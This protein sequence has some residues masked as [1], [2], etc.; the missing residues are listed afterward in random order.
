[1]SDKDDKTIDKQD[2]ESVTGIVGTETSDTNYDDVNVDVTDN[3]TNANDKQDDSSANEDNAVTID[4]NANH[5]DVQSDRCAVDKPSNDE[6]T[7]EVNENNSYDGAHDGINSDASVAHDADII[8]ENDDNKQHAE[9]D[10]N[11]P[12]SA[13]DDKEFDNEKAADIQSTSDG[14]EK[15]DMK[16]PKHKID[17]AKK[18]ATI[19]CVSG[20]VLGGSCGY[21]LIPRIQTGELAGK[22]ELTTSEFDK[23]IATYN[24]KGHSYTIT[25]AEVAD[26]EGIDYG[27]DSD[28]NSNSNE[29]NSSSDENENDNEN[30]SGKDKTYDIPSTEDTIAAIRDKIL[31]KEM[32]DKKIEASDKQIKEYAKDNYGSDDFDSLASQYNVDKNVVE[33]SIKRSVR[34]RELYKQITGDYAPDRPNAPTSPSDTSDSSAYTNKTEDYGSYLMSI[35]KNDYDADKNEWKNK[36]GD[37]YEALKDEDFDGKTASYSTCVKAYK[38][39]YAQYSEQYDKQSK[40]WQ[41]YTTDL[42]ANTDVH[43]TNIMPSRSSN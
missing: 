20:L 17:K 25:A 15:V 26:Y 35:I 29:S 1:M 10:S 6:H 41:D 43:F 5:A 22:S 12:A 21:W 31:T 4:D 19:A 3:M 38:I 2:N 7:D 24:F 27:K 13:S 23:V 42:Y 36:S 39:A 37:Y 11:E 9:S 18:I 40:K 28:S 32:D 33:K 16:K 14:D 30:S 34:V 8:A